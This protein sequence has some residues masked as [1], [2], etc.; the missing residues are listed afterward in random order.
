MICCQELHRRLICS[1][2]ICPSG[3]LSHL[4]S[5]LRTT[6]SESVTQGTN[7]LVTTYQVCPGHPE[8]TAKSI[9]LAT[10]TVSWLQQHIVQWVLIIVD[11]DDKLLAS[12]NLPASPQ[13]SI[14]LRKEN[15]QSNHLSWLGMILALKQAYA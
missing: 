5:V 11:S 3:G 4:S 7:Q 9:A 14:T 13:L 2:K 10:F 15:S 1:D 6:V 8:V 12:F